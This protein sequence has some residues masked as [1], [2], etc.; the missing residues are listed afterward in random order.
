MYKNSHHTAVY[1]CKNQKQ[2]VGT[3]QIAENSEEVIQTL[4]IT[5]GW[6]YIQG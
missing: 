3:T 1:D 4:I 2:K 6:V 5:E